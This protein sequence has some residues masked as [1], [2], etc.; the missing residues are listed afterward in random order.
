MEWKP[1]DRV[2]T[3]GENGT[4]LNTK[5]DG[6]WAHVEWDNGRHTLCYPT[7][8]YPGDTPTQ[9]DPVDHPTHYTADPSGIECIEITRHRNFNVGCAIK[10]LWRAGLKDSDAHIQD[11]KKA[12]W[13][14][15]DE[16]CRLQ[17]DSK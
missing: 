15:N 4:I 5:E 12:A 16:I 17:G 6:T 9:N 13:Y 14:I 8:L 3:N 1:G 11:L 7:S 2:K 10:Y